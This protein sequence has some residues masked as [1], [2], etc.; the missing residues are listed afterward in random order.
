MK[1]GKKIKIQRPIPEGVGRQE[2]NPGHG[3]KEG[4]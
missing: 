2:G 1:R 3:A 4:K